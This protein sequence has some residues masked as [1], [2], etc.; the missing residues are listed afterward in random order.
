MFQI[1]FWF[2]VILKLWFFIT[3][4]NL[5][6]SSKDFQIYDTKQNP[7]HSSNN[8]INEIIFIYIILGLYNYATFTSLY[9]HWV[10]Y[11][12]KNATSQY[13]TINSSI[14]IYYQLKLVCSIFEHLVNFI[15]NYVLFSNIF[16]IVNE[17]NFITTN[18]SY[19]LT[20]WKS[21]G[22]KG[23][24]SERTFKNIRLAKSYL[25]IKIWKHMKEDLTSSNSNTFC[26]ALKV[27]LHDFIDKFEKTIRN[28]N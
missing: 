4:S 22:W 10:S 15:Y 14:Y 17:I 16:G 11:L 7:L 20:Y 21:I 25:C 6:A 23:C 18:T 2:A 28:R 8:T 24:I 26:T 5:I 13:T 3:L 19:L 9:D 12:T 27:P 1:P